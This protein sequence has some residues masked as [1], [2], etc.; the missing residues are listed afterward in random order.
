[1][2]D[3]IEVLDSVD[4]M[5]HFQDGKFWAEMMDKVVRMKE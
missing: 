2:R 5:A 4:E 1:L 3:V